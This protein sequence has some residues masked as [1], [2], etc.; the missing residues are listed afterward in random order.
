MFIIEKN[1]HKEDQ[2]DALK[3]AKEII[4]KIYIETH[5]NTTNKDPIK[6]E[7]LDETLSNNL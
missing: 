4:K 5:Y 3:W 1:I 2:S 7:D 6:V